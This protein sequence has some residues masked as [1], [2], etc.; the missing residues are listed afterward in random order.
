M[1]KMIVV[2]VMAAMIAASAF[3]QCPSPATASFTTVLTCPEALQCEASLC[4]CAS[5]GSAASG[6]ACLR[7]TTSAT[8]ACNLMPTCFSNYVRCLTALA[9]SARSNT[10]SSCSMWAMTVHAQVLQAATGTF[11]GSTLERDC[12]AATCRLRNQTGQTS[13]NLGGANYTNVCTYDNLIAPGTTTNSGGNPPTTSSASAVSL[14][15][16]AVLAAVA[17]LL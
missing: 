8:F 4:S 3:A 14:G 11:A 16:A 12:V 17:A 10:S 1:A 6:T 2:L 7:N 5:A 13:C 9:N 15:V